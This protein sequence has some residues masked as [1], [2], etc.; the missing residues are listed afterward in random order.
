MAQECP[1]AEAGVGQVFP[2]LEPRGDVLALLRFEAEGGGD[3]LA[4]L[5]FEAEGNGDGLAVLC[6]GTG[7]VASGSL[8][9]FVIAALAAGRST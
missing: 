9:N 8:T 2:L 1:G 7:Q 5:L 3:G 4:F 6:V